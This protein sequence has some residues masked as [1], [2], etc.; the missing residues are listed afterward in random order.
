MVSRSRF[1]KSNPSF[2]GSRIVR[3]GEIHVFGERVADDFR[4]LGDLLGHEMA[5]VALVDEKRGSLGER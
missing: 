3:F 5:V 2:P 4:L 1:A